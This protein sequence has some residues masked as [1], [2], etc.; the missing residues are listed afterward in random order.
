MRGGEEGREIEERKQTTLEEKE[1]KKKKQPWRDVKYVT[2]E[3]LG[4]GNANLLCRQWP[5]N[6]YPGLSGS[7]LYL[8]T[9]YFVPGHYSILVKILK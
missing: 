1:K 4:L 2:L 9:P 7:A 3:N 8:S 6:G 5:A